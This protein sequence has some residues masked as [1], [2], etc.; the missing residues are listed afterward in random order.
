MYQGVTLKLG[1]DNTIKD[2]L[3]VGTSKL[4]VKMVTLY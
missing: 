3:L 2:Q 1:C 4:L